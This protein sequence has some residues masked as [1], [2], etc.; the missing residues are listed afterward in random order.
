MRNDNTDNMIPLTFRSCMEKLC[1]L[2]I[3]AMLFTLPMIYPLKLSQP[4]LDVVVPWFDSHEG[5][6][7]YLWDWQLEPFLY[8]GLSPLILK[9]AVMG[10]FV[11]FLAGAY[12]LWKISAPP[13]KSKKSLTLPYV[14]LFIVLIYIGFSALF[15]SPTMHDSIMGFVTLL[16][17]VFFFIAAADLRKPQFFIIKA[18]ILTG[19]TSFF[20]MI[21]SLIQYLGL[22]SGFMLKMDRSRN[23]MG[24]FIGH[25]TG[26]SS[27]L[28][29]AFFLSL[30]ALTFVKNKIFRGTLYLFLIFQGFIL[31]AAQSRGVIL[32][33]ILL[34]P[35]FIYYLSRTT[36][37]RIPWK[38]ILMAILIVIILVL[39]QMINRP[40]NPF[41]N[42]EAPL[43]KRLEA[44]RP[45]NLRGTRL[46]ILTCSRHLLRESPVIGRGFDSFQYVYPAAQ[47]EYYA[48]HPETLLMVT[49]FRTKRAHN[50]YLKTAIEL[51]FFGLAAALLV[52]YL[53]L[54]KGQDIF[55][56][57]KT[58]REK[59][60]LCA[61]FFSITAYL[62]HSFMDFPMQIPP[63]TILFLFLFAVWIS[64]DKSEENTETLY[65]KLVRSRAG[66][67]G[68][69]LIILFILGLSPLANAVILRPYRS[70]LIFF[71]ADMYIQTVHE[72]NRISDREKL[73]LLQKAV[74]TAR[75]GNRLDP[76]N[77]ELE[78]KL[79]EAHYLLGALYMKQWNNALKRND[80]KETNYWKSMA[81][82][83]L[84]A[85]VNRIESA[86]GSFRFHA[87]YYL[88]G[89]VHENLNQVFPGE[90]HL[91][92]ARENYALA[93][94]FSPAFAPAL[95][96][97]SDLL[98]EISKQ[99][100]GADRAEIGREI[101]RVRKLIARHQPDYF[102]KA[103]VRKAQK[104]MLE[105]N[106]DKAIRLLMDIIRIEP[107]NIKY[108]TWLATAF[109]ESGSPEKALK[110]LER[111]SGID[112]EHPDIYDSY[113]MAFLKKRNYK[114]ALEYIRKRLEYEASNDD[115]FKVLEALTLKE[116]GRE[117]QSR[118][119]IDSLLSDENKKPQYL[120]IMGMT[121]IDYFNRYQ[122]GIEYLQRRIEMAPPPAAQVYYILAKHEMK[123]GNPV[124]A[125]RRLE[126]ALQILPDYKQAREL[127]QQINSSRERD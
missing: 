59:T 84:K 30:A 101:L 24:S 39:L 6:I 67:V 9:A 83:N 26:L 48:S 1:R 21:I 46:R 31:I 94:R 81:G 47:A 3:L 117:N 122:Q 44:F 75:M 50:D 92:K 11:V 95:R 2:T 93:I 43:I 127:L 12:L 123:Q 41:Y 99:L 110:V 54:K 114:K 100:S 126:R 36:E 40:W 103:F 96:D 71:K 62:I 10:G 102:D 104:A 113:V 51:G 112:P 55:A 58:K 82:R 49:E 23:L 60:L 52:L 56:K 87:V 70:D 115:I 45:E 38:K 79:G 33:L 109:T 80:S 86:L 105:Q 5:F 108:H 34:T 124:I 4:V 18:F 25:N 7:K 97:Y 27:Y 111:A 8:F 107:E 13:R 57:V 37:W 35:L 85:A 120:Q 119:K 61:V 74:S 65:Q 78:F 32:I 28:M 68:F 15:I 89:V 20:L 14:C 121:S 53:F 66:R 116:L 90:G 76:L 29:P 69:I 72:F 106:Y 98:T 17:A 64:G 125:R 16:T 77:G 118:K 42:Q 73:D 19:L 88:L 63:N 91:G 22:T